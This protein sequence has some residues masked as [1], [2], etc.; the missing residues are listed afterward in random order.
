VGVTVLEG[1]GVREGSVLGLADLVGVSPP[2][3]L[4]DRVGSGDEEG[5]LVSDI[6]LDCVGL[7]EGL[8]V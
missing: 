6:D 7:S 2:T 4:G 5:D 1:V 8:R 3:F